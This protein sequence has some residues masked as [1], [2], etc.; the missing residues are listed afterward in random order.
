MFADELRVLTE[1]YRCP[2]IFLEIHHFGAKHL[3][4]VPPRW[5]FTWTS[6]ASLCLSH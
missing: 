4:P 1:V 5:V 3:H 6:S 2:G